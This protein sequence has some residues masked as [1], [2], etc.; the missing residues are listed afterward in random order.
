MIVQQEPCVATIR[1]DEDARLVRAPE[2]GA[3]GA[4]ASAADQLVAVLKQGRG[5]LMIRP[6]TFGLQDSCSS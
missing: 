4:E 6:R 2:L 5:R 1:Y 3:A